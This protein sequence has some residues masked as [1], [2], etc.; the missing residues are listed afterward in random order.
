MRPSPHH[1]APSQGAA[2]LLQ[3]SSDDVGSTSS[4]CND[5]VQLKT[6]MAAFKAELS[7]LS[8]SQQL[9]AAMNLR[10]CPPG[11]AGGVPAPTGTGDTMI[12]DTHS[13]R[14]IPPLQPSVPNQNGWM[15]RLGWNALIPSPRQIMKHG[16]KP[17]ES[18]RMLLQPQIKN[19]RDELMAK[20]KRGQVGSARLLSIVYKRL[21]EPV[22]TRKKCL[23]LRFERLAAND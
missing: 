22:S 13:V 15:S 2:N 11:E 21:I 17:T 12:A 5:N 19:M 14:L 6:A 9:N 10:Q 3:R 18:T 4:V 7:E 16:A 23:C 20:L 8:R 1:G